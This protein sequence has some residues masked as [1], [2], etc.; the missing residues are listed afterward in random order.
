MLFPSNLK[1]KLSYLTILVGLFLIVGY[2]GAVTLDN[3]LSV[4][5]IPELLEKIV[6]AVAGIIAAVATIMITWSGI[7]FITSTGNEQRMTNAKKAF[8]YAIIG[9]VV[10]ISASTIITVVKAILSTR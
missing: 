3:P 1:E 10:A 8:F 5:T 9:F 2:V 6:L 7:L 4:N